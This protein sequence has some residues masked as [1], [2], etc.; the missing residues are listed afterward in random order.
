MTTRAKGLFTEKAL[1]L[2]AT[3]FSFAG[4]LEKALKTN[5]TRLQNILKVIETSKKRKNK[6]GGRQ[7]GAAEGH[8]EMGSELYRNQDN[9]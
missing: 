6:L 2:L 8:G 5:K 4:R 1:V 9:A 7:P 3:H